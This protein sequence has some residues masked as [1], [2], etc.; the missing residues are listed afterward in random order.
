MT[1]GFAIGLTTAMLGLCVGCTGPSRR[2]E[3][4]TGVWEGTGVFVLD[5][6]TAQEEDQA[7]TREAVDHGTYPTHLKIEPTTIDDAPAVR[8]EILSQRGGMKG[9]P[10]LGDRTHLILLLKRADDLADGRIALYELTKIGLS[11]SQAAPE[12]HDGPAGTTLA[13]RFAINGDLVLHLLYQN[14]WVDRLRF[15]GDRVYKDGEYFDL[16]SGYIHWSEVLHRKR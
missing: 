11:V 9:L 2:A 15:H 1:R 3:I 16:D 12:M 8:L 14:G 13:S 6:W 5:K 4:P 10:D 7:A